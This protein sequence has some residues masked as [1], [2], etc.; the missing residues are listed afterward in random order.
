MSLVLIAISFIFG[1]LREVTMG[2][3]IFTGVVFG[4]VFRLVQSLLGP[5]SVVFGFAP[6]IA[7]AIPILLC[8]LLGLY[9]LNR[10]R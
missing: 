10:T 6:I 9:L 4:V 3:R 7:V 8:G 5:S 2:Q 1:P